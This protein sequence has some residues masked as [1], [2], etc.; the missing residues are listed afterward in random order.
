MGC[1]Q[2]AIRDCSVTGL[3][4]FVPFFSTKKK[5]PGIASRICNKI[6]LNDLA[7]MTYILH[8]ICLLPTA[9]QA[10]SLSVS[11]AENQIKRSIKA[12]EIKASE[13]I[14]EKKMKKLLLLM[15]SKKL[16]LLKT[17]DFLAFLIKKVLLD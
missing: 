12:F 9:L 3:S 5:Y 2:F 4:S 1:L 6:F 14:F 13:G 8:E 15:S 16:M 17:T 11:R 10:R 7:S